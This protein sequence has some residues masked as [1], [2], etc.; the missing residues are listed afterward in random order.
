MPDG[1]ESLVD[2]AE[3]VLDLLDR[4]RRKDA[5]LREENATLRAELTGINKECRELK[6]DKSDRSEQF[7]SRLLSVMNKLDELEKLHR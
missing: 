2:K 4:V 7:K 3:K 6:L 1:Y 5:A